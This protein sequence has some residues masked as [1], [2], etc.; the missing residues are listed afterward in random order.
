[1]IYLTTGANGSGKTLLTIYDVR[2]QQIKESRPVYY[3]GFES[4][5]ELDAF[6]WKKFDPKLWQDLPDGSICIWDECQNELPVRPSGSPVPDYVNAIAQFRRKRGFDFWLI[7]PHPSLID[8]FVRRL[9]GPPSWHRHVLRTFG[10]DLVSVTTYATAEMSCDRPGASRNGETT[11]RPFPKEAYTWYRSASLHTGKRRIPRVVWVLCLSVVVLIACVYGAYYVI[12]SRYLSPV[13]PAVAPAVP[14]AADGAAKPA[15][16][17]MPAVPSPSGR[18][19]ARVLTGAEY[20]I[21]RMPRIDGLPQTAPV[22]DAVTQPVVA[23]YPAACISRASKCTCYTQQGTRLDTSRDLCIQI[24]ERGYFIDWQ[25]P[26]Q[27]QPVASGQLVVS[28]PAAGYVP[29]P[30]PV[31]SPP[32]ASRP[33]SAASATR[34]AAPQASSFMAYLPPSPGSAGDPLGGARDGAVIGALRAG[35]RLLPPA[36]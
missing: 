18:A 30:A 19:P 16:A 21:A 28:P 23:P 29:A 36:H 27:L 14:G 32:A 15:S 33:Q 7:T 6:G 11:M 31:A 26:Q 12:R 17:P 25:Q 22:Y 24:V 20:A 34:A 3:H 4:T 13:A 2:Q 8:L 10:A 35:A 1:M 9:V 5:P